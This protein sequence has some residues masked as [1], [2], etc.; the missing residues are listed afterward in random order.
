MI[1]VV[2]VRLIWRALCRQSMRLVEQAHTTKRLR[3][4]LKATNPLKLTRFSNLDFHIKSQWLSEL[5]LIRLWVLSETRL[6]LLTSKSPF[7]SLWMK[8]QWLSEKVFAE[9]SHAAN[10][11]ISKNKWLIKASRMVI[12]TQRALH[13]NKSVDTEVVV[14]FK[15]IQRQMQAR[16]TLS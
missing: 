14:G 13:G 3:V 5:V 11:E 9:C 4:C 8:L 10:S 1:Q 7:I 2:H 16:R 6:A 15:W 12:P